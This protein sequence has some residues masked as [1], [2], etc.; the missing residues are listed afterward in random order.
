MPRKPRFFLPNVP[1]HI[2]IRGNSRKIIFAED[3]DY[4]AYLGW[5]KEGAEKHDCQIHAY[6]LMSNHVH[7]LV[8]ANHPQNLSKLLQAVG[9]RYV[10]FFNHKYGNSGTLWEGR[11]KASSIDSEQYL[12][13]CYRYIELNPV[14]AHMVKKP[15]EY[16]WSSYRV[17]ALGENN[18]IITPHPLY[19]A[20]GNNK[21]QRTQ[22]YRES[23]KEA[24]D[25][26]LIN[27]IQAS[28][29]TGTPM[30]SERFKTEIEKPLGAKV[31]QSRRGRPARVEK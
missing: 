29:Q 16:R 25:E 24:L 20:L 8:S 10:P 4:H 31:G 27:E 1:V 13:T 6:V 5:L 14:R 21:Q 23:F 12:L 28:V 26:K 3:D 2:V 7:L 22:Y 9:R 11:F 15:K 17:N 18:P 19:L 30:G